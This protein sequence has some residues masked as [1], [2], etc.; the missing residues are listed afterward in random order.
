M[1]ASLHRGACHRPP[2][3][4]VTPLLLW[5]GALV[6]PNPSFGGGNLT[7]LVKKMRL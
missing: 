1:L 7:S 3:F 4:K 2:P 5:L 6:S